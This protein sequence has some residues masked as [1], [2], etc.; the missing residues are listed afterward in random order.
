[1][2]AMIGI[3]AQSA[4]VAQAG[5]G[6]F[7]SPLTSFFVCH[8]INGDDPGKVVDLQSPVFGPDRQSVRIGNGTLACAWARLFQAGTTIEISPNPPTT[9]DTLKCY[10]VSVS[11][12]TSGP[13]LYIFADVLGGE[14]TQVQASE[15]RYICGPASLSR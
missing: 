15:L 13:A 3:L 4:T 11:R 6:G 2:L 1:M 8:S 9:Y 12:K 14:E 7:V 10:T 5:A